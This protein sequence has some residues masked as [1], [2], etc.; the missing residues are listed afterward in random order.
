M[1]TG[2]RRIVQ[3]SEVL[4]SHLHKSKR[5]SKLGTRGAKQHAMRRKRGTVLLFRDEIDRSDS[6]FGNATPRAVR[7]VP[8]RRSRATSHARVAE[9]SG[10]RG[11]KK[12][13]NL[14]AE[15]ICGPACPKPKNFVVARLLSLKKCEPGPTGQDS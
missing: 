2:A 12:K 7:K 14:F 5:V 8:A 3:G 6:V 4:I 9:I 1:Q 15:K 13:A 10:W 11:Q